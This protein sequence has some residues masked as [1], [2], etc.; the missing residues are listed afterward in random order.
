MLTFEDSRIVDAEKSPETHVDDYWCE[1]L[2]DCNL[3]VWTGWANCAGWLVNANV[4]ARPID[5]KSQV[6]YTT[7]ISFGGAR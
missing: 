7:G 4:V 2:T 6:I 5:K 3:L 1:Q